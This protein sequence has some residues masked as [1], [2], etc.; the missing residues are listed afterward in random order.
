LKFWKLFSTFLSF[1]GIAIIIVIGIGIAVFVASTKD[2]N[3]NQRD[4]ASSSSTTGYYAANVQIFR[5]P[6]FQFQTDK[7]WS[8]ATNESKDGKY[9]YRSIRNSL[10][11]HEFIVYVGKATPASKPVTRVLPVSIAS[12]NTLKA[13]EI[14][15]H[16]SNALPPGQKGGIKVVT[17]KSVTFDCFADNTQY[18]VIV[19]QIGGTPKLSL[20]RPDGGKETYTIYYSNVTANPES[21]QLQQII[22]SFQTR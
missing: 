17:Y 5:T 15:D 6:Y 3:I 14:S 16:C 18:N 7:S 9:V 19:G 20:L 4:Q 22:A 2:K 1:L 10:I 12:E 8:E 13:N 21:S 11:K